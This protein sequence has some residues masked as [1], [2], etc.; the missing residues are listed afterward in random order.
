MKITQFIKFLEEKSDKS[1]LIT[2][3]WI[4][5][6]VKQLHKYSAFKPD[7]PTVFHIQPAFTIARVNKTL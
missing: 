1:V 7:F 2:V 5:T 6:E 4:V 3:L